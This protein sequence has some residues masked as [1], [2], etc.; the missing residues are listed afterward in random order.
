MKTNINTPDVTD[1]SAMYRIKY[2]PIEKRRFE[3]I[4]KFKAYVYDLNNEHLLT[5]CPNNIRYLNS[6]IVQEFKFTMSGVTTTHEYVCKK[7][8]VFDGASLPAKLQFLVKDLSRLGYAIHDD[9][10][11]HQTIF[12][13]L[14]KEREDFKD[15]V[16]KDGRFLSDKRRR[17]HYSR[18]L[19][20]KYMGANHSFRGV[21]GYRKMI[22]Y[23][24]LRIFGSVAFNSHRAVD[25]NLG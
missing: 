17:N 4:A 6:N 15:H 19:S 12:N 9:N 21:T 14:M 5:K 11:K 18:I 25:K 3:S 20:D 8:L 16:N 1:L 2:F 13:I 10:Y 23:I 22:A 7:G 24:P